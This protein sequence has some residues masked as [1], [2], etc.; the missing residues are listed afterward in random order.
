MTSKSPN[1]NNDWKHKFDPD[2]SGNERSWKHSYNNG[3]GY[4]SFTDDD[5][6]KPLEAGPADISFD[7]ND[8]SFV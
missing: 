4:M 2:R 8:G 3:S 6:L 5:S 1:D 7:E